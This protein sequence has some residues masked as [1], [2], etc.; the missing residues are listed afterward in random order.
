MTGG[1][2]GPLN[3][4]I[5]YS[6]RDDDLREEFA[7]QLSQLERDGVLRWDDRRL[8]GGDE[9]KGVIDERLNTADIILLLIST[10]FLASKYC[11]DVEM[12]RALERHDQDHARVVPVILRPCDWKHSPFA[13]FNALPKDGKPV[14]DWAT[15]DHGFFNVVQGLRRL[16]EELRKQGAPSSRPEGAKSGFG[17]FPKVYSWRRAIAVGAG[18][19]LF[20]AVW[21]W[22]S[23]Q[24]QYIAQGEK[25]LDVGHYVEARPFLQ[26]A[27][28]WNPFSARAT[29]GLETAKLYDLISNG[30]EF[31]QKLNQL[32]REAPNDAHLKVL[33]G[34]YELAQDQR[35]KALAD[36]QKAAELNP[37]VAE[38][39]F[40]MCV[41]YDM[42]RNLG[43]ALPACQKA[44]DL[45]P[46]SPHYRANLAAQYFKHGEYESAIREYTKALQNY[47]EA[48]LGLAKI[49]RLQGELE[50]ALEKEQ[51]AIQDLGSDSVMA[52]YENSLPW[53]FEVT[54]NEVVSIPGRDQKLCYA[55]LELSATLYLSGSDSQAAASFDQAAKACGPQ[56][57]DLKKVLDRE[58]TR[59]ADERSEL[60]TRVDNFRRNLPA[61]GKGSQ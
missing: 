6:H 23:K 48:K 9:W 42:Q 30:V 38:G 43:R 61:W 19:L 59:V 26:Q 8:E 37:R 15:H 2:S 32:S 46:F 18:A 21:L 10:D 29:H 40:R 39:Y 33:E 20:A 27:L 12:K 14:V 17:E 25:E 5:S 35:D 45:S 24:Q 1:T 3:L 56:S 41:L 55:H 47:P 22:W 57:L 36:Y 54:P 11:Y 52:S 49:L 44:V 7:K 34:D 16:V 51:L 60:A 13:R 53:I 58:L 28:Q 31:G 4:F 50:E